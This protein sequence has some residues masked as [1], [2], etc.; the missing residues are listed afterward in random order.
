MMFRAT[1]KHSAVHRSC[2][3]PINYFAF[4]AHHSLRKHMVTAR[5]KNTCIMDRTYCIVT[6]ILRK[7]NRLS[8]FPKSQISL[9][10]GSCPG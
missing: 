4:C 8:K 9:V 10:K 3:Y 5:K 7:K 6:D 1:A 2:T